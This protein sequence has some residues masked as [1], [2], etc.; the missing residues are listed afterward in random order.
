[1]V[2][3][4]DSNASARDAAPVSGL[5]RCREFLA[6]CAVVLSSTACA[7]EPLPLPFVFARA[8]CTQEDIPGVEIFLTASAWNGEGS[9]PPPYVHIEAAGVR[10]RTYSAIPLTPGRRDPAQ[11]L[12]AR[13]QF[14][15]GPG[16]SVRL[17]GTLG[18]DQKGPHMPIHGTYHFCVDG[19]RCFDGSFVADWRPGPAVCG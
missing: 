15:A 11:P 18:F 9:P 1:M 5:L 8:G 7:S 2:S 17:T 16:P 4:T 3:S 6:A 19:G 14:R 10:G 12:L 13:A